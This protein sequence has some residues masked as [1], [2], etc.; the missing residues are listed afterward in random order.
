MDEACCIHVVFGGQ[1][2]SVPLPTSTDAT[3]Q[4]LMKAI[5]SVI[6]VPFYKQRLI[7]KGRSLTDC[8]ALISACGLTA[9]SKVMV[10]GSV[11]TLDPNEAEKLS[12]AKSTSES[13]SLELENLSEK[14]RNIND[15]NG[16][17]VTVNVKCTVDIMERCMRTLELLDSVRLPYDCENERTCR[18]QL[19]DTI[20]EFLVQ[21]D[22]LRGEFLKLAKTKT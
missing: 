11:E 12:K 4:H 8:D 13:I 14:L 6:H 22:K 10:L 20:Q 18:K 15:S 21:A 2:Y 19:V 1:K 3:L 9:G 5:E 7:F 16:S 17:E